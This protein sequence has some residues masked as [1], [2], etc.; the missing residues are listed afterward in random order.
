MDINLTEHRVNEIFAYIK[1]K[2]RVIS[3]EDF[4]LNKNEFI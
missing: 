4:E 3:L 2:K 1:K